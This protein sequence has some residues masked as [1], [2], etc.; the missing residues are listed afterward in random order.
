MDILGSIQLKDKQTKKQIVTEI[1]LPWILASR[2]DQ[3]D[4]AGRLQDTAEDRN[5]T[6]RI[7]YAEDTASVHCHDAAFTECM[8]EILPEGHH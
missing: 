7:L 8:I 4:Q 6:L 3:G 1:D 2:E 5:K